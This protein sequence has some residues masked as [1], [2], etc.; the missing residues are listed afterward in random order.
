M[1]ITPPGMYS[2]VSVH[3]HLCCPCSHLGCG[4]KGGGS[5]GV[6]TFIQ[7][8]P[9]FIPVV[10]A[11]SVDCGSFNSANGLR[12]Q[13][14]TWWPKSQPGIDSLFLL[15][16]DSGAQLGPW[17]DAAALS[18]SG[19]APRDRA[20]RAG[21]WGHGCKHMLS[22]YRSPPMGCHPGSSPRCSSSRLHLPSPLSHPP[23]RRLENTSTT[24]GSERQ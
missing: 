13:N 1:S 12:A 9:P 4:N 16:C 22:L 15:F 6:S 21:H 19:S 10:T 8:K 3:I 20:P 5:H 11:E 18:A 7:A 24:H 17:W 2:C 14:Q 23:C